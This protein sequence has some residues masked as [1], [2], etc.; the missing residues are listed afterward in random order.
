MAPMNNGDNNDIGE[1]I[2][3][4]LVEPN[5]GDTRLFEENFRDAKLANAVHAV[6]DGEEALDFVYQRGDYE[7]APRPN[8]ILLEL[9]LSGMSGQDV[10]SELESEEA[11]SEIPVIVLTGSKAGEDLV[12]SSGIDADEY[13]QKPVEA[14]EFIEF[15]QEVEDFWFA[16]V[17]NDE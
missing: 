8:L 17:K 11:L 13:I 16:V 14:E 12:K 3:I 7:D 4:L 5:P 1:A 2:D 10:L 9:Q 6:T 15:V